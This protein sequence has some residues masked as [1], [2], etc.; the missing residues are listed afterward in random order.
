MLQAARGKRRTLPQLSFRN[1]PQRIH[2]FFMLQA[3]SLPRRSLLE[4]LL[5]EC[6]SFLCCKRLKREEA[7]FAPALTFRDLPLSECISF[8]AAGNL[9]GKERTLPQR[10]LL[11]TPLSEFM[12]FSCRVLLIIRISTMLQYRRILKWQYRDFEVL[13]EDTSSILQ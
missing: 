6:M 1:L 7:H 3:A 10:F 11:E 4:N 13:H 2:K 9:R 8:N 5:S 12:S